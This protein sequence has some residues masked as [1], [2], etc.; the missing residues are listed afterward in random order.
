M[1]HEPIQ[2]K[3]AGATGDVIRK[4]ADYLWREKL[5]AFTS[6][7][8]DKARELVKKLNEDGK[9]SI[10]EFTDGQRKDLKRALL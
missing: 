3:L 6:N 4:I 5:V 8:P 7:H 10:S 9:F 1:D 2:V